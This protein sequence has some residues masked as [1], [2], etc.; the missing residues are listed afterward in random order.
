VDLAFRA[1]KIGHQGSVCK[2][3]FWVGKLINPT[4]DRRFPFHASKKLNSRQGGLAQRVRAKRGP[5]AGSGV[6]CPFIAGERR[7]TL[8]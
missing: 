7:I 5:K 1:A 4:M 6:S 2:L 3:F 8:R